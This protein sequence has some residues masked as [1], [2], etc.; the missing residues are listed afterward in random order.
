MG[1]KAWEVAGNSLISTEG[2]LLETLTRVK[3]TLNPIRRPGL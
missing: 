1:L 2:Y 3:R